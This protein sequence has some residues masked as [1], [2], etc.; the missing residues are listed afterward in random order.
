M[1]NLQATIIS[2]SAGK[3]SYRDFL[4]LYD[5]VHAEWV[6]G[7]VFIQM[8][9]SFQH[10][11]INAFLL[12]LVASFVRMNDLG[13]VMQPPFN[14]KLAGTGREPDLL[15][16]AKD[17]LDLMRESYFDGAADLA[18]EI[19]SPESGQ[20]D[21]VT[22]FNEYQTAQVKE[23]WIID[24]D[25]QQ[26]HFYQL[27]QNGI[28]QESKL[29]QEGKYLSKVLQGFW[30]NPAW[31]WQEPTPN[32]EVAMMEI[33]GATYAQFLIGELKNKGFLP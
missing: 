2:P 21:R 19:V 4:R 15:F 3:I 23:Y 17:R 26:A 7:E 27:D 6:N 1:T 13:E 12:S 9:A 33:A 11:K 5:G 8:T 18:V 31:L 20:R 10:Q 28:F 32:P 24:P 22:K 14:M 25:K 29:D 16:V 30:L